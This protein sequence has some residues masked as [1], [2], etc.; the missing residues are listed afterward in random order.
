LR[1]GGV[2]DRM[3]GG[4]V[5]V[6]RELRDREVL[7]V[8]GAIVV[9]GLLV[10]VDLL[11]VVG[12]LVVVVIR[13]PRSM[14]VVRGRG[15]MLVVRDVMLAARGVKLV[16]RPSGVVVGPRGLMVRPRGVVVRLASELLGGTVVVMPELSVP[17]DVQARPQLDAQ[18][19][20]QRR[21]HGEGRPSQH[22][23]RA[24]AEGMGQGT[25]DCGPGHEHRG[26]EA[27][28]QSPVRRVTRLH[29]RRID[30]DS[31]RRGTAQDDSDDR[32]SNGAA[33]RPVPPPPMKRAELGGAL[34]CQGW[35]L[36]GLLGALGL[37][38][39]AP[40]HAADPTHAPEPLTPP[41]EEPTEDAPVATAP[42]SSSPVATTPVSPAPA[43]ALDDDGTRVVTVQTTTGDGLTATSHRIDTATLRN[44]PKRTAE[45]LLRLVPGLLVVQHGNQGKGYQYYIRGFDAVHGADVEVLVDDVP[46]NERSNVHANGYLDMG[47]VIP[48]VVQTLEVKKGSVRLEQG[49]FATAG[50]VEYRL[51]VPGPYRGTQV[52]YELGSTGRHRAVVVHAPRS[53]GS[54]TFVAAS[55][56]TDQG[57][58]ENRHAQGATALAKARLWQDRDAFVDVLGGVY[59]ASFGLP[60]TVRLS[61]FNTGRVGFYDAYVHDTGGESARALAAGPAGVERGRGSLQLTAHAQ[62]RRLSLDENYTG[63]LGTIREFRDDP[64]GALG[65]RHTQQQEE[66]RGGLRL[67]G[68]WHVHPRV[69]LRL[70]GHWLGGT[71][72][73]RVDDLTPQRAIWRVERDMLIDQHELGIGPGVRWRALPWLRIE[74]GVR[75]EAYHARVRDRLQGGPRVG[76]TKFTLAPRFAAQ[77]LL[78]RHWQLFAAYGRGFRLPEA[79]AFT[80]PQVVPENV[81]LDQFRGG[82]PHMTVADNAEVGG[83]WQPAAFIDVG[84]AVFGTFIARESLFDHVSGFNIELGPTRRLGV[85]ADVQIRPTPWLGLG[86]SAVGNQ[87]RFT[88]TG[89]PVPGA[90]PFLAQVQG[91]LMHPK[92]WRAGLRWFAMGRRPLSYGATAGALTVLDASVGH[93]WKWIG[94]DLAVDNVLGARWRDGEYNFASHW[95]PDDAVSA[96]PTI[97]FVAGPPRMFRLSAS[98]RF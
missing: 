11:V 50:S 24:S 47:F 23:P 49:A 31:S 7:L 58:G 34:G 17:R 63:S 94:V 6:G 48:E 51:G 53:R 14:L 67:H 78:G 61:D 88:T 19:P 81:D 27:T 2:I 56:F 22:G 35:M 4:R 21:D 39:H 42:T 77:A 36:A 60:G 73:Q 84:A 64:R 75:A 40:A 18:E 62:L 86:V 20:H 90:P 5:L 37:G 89:A 95:N 66:A 12:P 52:G 92:G 80:L 8:V 93:Q 28:P 96:L 54:E 41:S 79:R 16:V 85:E 87:A 29:G 33:A 3:S 32:A 46:I 30:L 72:D 70:E 45:D 91:T 9:A 69:T 10:V 15:V 83:R 55:A 74:A 65:D 25:H 44:T 57:Y 38:L 13:S 97:H 82:E 1:G 68:H 76:G 71:V 98:V 26:V 59:A 43:P